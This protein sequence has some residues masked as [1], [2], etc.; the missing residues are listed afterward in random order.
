MVKRLCFSRKKRLFFIGNLLSLSEKQP[1]FSKNSSKH[2]ENP[3]VRFLSHSYC[4]ANK[5][6]ECITEF[7]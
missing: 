6:G 1:F 2:R 3:T 7:S 4:F 5:T